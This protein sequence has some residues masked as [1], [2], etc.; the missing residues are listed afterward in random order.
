MILWR[1]DVG[2]HE[3]HAWRARRYA[4]SGAETGPLGYPRTDMRPVVGTRRG[5]VSRFERGSIRRRFGL[6]NR[7]TKAVVHWSP[8]T[9]AHWCARGPIYRRYRIEGGASGPPGFPAADQRTTGDRRIEVPFEHG[10]ITND[11]DSGE[12][13]VT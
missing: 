3:I 2:A 6:W 1:R 11:P 10:T 5:Q 4:R 13:T 9:G 8:D 12:L 7:F